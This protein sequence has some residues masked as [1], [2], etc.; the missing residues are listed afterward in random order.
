[1][2]RIRIGDEGLRGIRWLIDDAVISCTP[3]IA[4]DMLGSLP[5]S[6]ARIGVESDKNASEERPLSDRAPR[7]LQMGE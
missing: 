3:Q 6:W 1:M 2:I 5:V 7:G 4:Q